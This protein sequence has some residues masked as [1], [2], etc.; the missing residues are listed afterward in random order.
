M[1][2]AARL[3]LTLNTKQNIKTALENK[4]RTPSDVFS[5][6][7]AEIDAISTGIGDGAVVPAIV[8]PQDGATGIIKTKV[9][10]T[11]TAFA[12]IP[13]TKYAQDWAQW[14]I[15]TDSGFGDVIFDSGEDS[16]NLQSIDVPGGIIPA[17]TKLYARVRY[18]YSLA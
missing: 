9:T 4:G 18:G 11:A 6:Y 1:T 3:Q 5:T 16:S 8:M 13:A 10:L 12:S 15:A 17:G 7:P 2:T 14:Q